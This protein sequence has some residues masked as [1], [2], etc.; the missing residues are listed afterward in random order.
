ML[1]ANLR[2]GIYD[3]LVVL[4][5]AGAAFVVSASFTQ[6]YAYLSKLRALTTPP[7]EAVAA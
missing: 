4:Q 7:A 6:F 3:W 1:T 2:H 5:P